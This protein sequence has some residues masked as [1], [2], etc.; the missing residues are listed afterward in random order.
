M[1]FSNYPMLY[2]PPGAIFVNRVGSYP[3]PAGQTVDVLVARSQQIVIPNTYTGWVALAGVA[4]SDYASSN[5]SL[6]VNG[7]QLRDYAQMTAPIGAPETIQPV[8]IQL[9]PQ[10]PFSLVVYNGTANPQAVRWRFFGWYYTLS[11]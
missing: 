2:P 4:L 7:I 9:A 11:Q 1:D 3:V 5:F 6:T 8:Y 10:Q